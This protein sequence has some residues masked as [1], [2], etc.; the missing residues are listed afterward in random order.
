MSLNGWI[1]GWRGVRL[2]WAEKELGKDG[3]SFLPVVIRLV[4]H[5]ETEEGMILIGVSG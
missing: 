5:S 1:G 2:F 3:E 4:L